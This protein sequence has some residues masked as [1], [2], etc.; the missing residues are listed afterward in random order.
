MDIIYFLLEELNEYLLSELKILV[1][2]P[3]LNHL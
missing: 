1:I 3:R 2:P